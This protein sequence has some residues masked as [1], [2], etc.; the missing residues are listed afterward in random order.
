VPSDPLQ[1]YCTA[2]PI[3]RLWLARSIVERLRQLC[4]TVKFWAT[5]VA[6]MGQ[7][8]VA[9]LVQAVNCGRAMVEGRVASIDPVLL[10]IERSNWL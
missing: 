1:F 10:Y 8:L 2:R 9:G 4:Q 3:L 5:Q 6:V 7:A